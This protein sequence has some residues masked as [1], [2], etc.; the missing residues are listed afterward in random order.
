MFIGSCVTVLIL[1]FCLP[2]ILDS[3]APPSP[4]LDHCLRQGR[5]CDCSRIGNLHP[6]FSVRKA[7]QT[8]KTACLAFSYDTPCPWNLHPVIKS[9]TL[10]HDVIRVSS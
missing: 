3:S 5:L 8:L 2:L 4:C 1:L 7:H 9:T 10:V 6:N